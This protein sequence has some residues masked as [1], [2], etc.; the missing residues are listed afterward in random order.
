[1]QGV[2]RHFPEKENGLRLGIPAGTG[3][4]RPYFCRGR[5]PGSFPQIVSLLTKS[6][7]TIIDKRKPQPGERMR[8]PNF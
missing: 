5:L 4:R 2:R 1:M 7:Q 8:L 3:I 6:H